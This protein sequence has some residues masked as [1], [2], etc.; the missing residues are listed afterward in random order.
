VEDK[1]EDEEGEEGEEEDE[2]VREESSEF[3]EEEEELEERSTDGTSL[4][5]AREGAED[6]TMA[7]EDGEVE[8]RGEGDE[9][10]SSGAMSEER[11]RG[12]SSRSWGSFWSSGSMTSMMYGKMAKRKAMKKRLKRRSVRRLNIVCRR[13]RPPRTPIEL[14]PRPAA[15]V[16]GR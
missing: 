8:M 7:E 4:R 16:A 12:A 9:V 3:A 2:E 1:D 10:G 15:R 13:R 6:S 11:R 5:R 14:R